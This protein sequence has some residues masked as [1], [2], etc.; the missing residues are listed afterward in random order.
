MKSTENR[1]V[2][3]STCCHLALEGAGGTQ[4]RVRGKVH[5][6]NL[7][8]TPSSVLRTSS[9]SR[10]KQTPNA[11]TLIELLV[12]VL[13]IGI[14]AAVALPQYKKAVIKSRTTEALTMLKTIAD[15]Q[16]VYY[17]S[18]GE[19]TNN[20]SDLDID[21]DEQLVGTWSTGKFE[22]KYTYACIEKRTCGAYVNNKDMPSFE[23]ELLH[24][25]AYLLNAGKKFCKVSGKS[26]IAKSICQSMGTQNAA[27]YNYLYSIN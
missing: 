10:G 26:N 16:E 7:I 12:V 19:Y 3:K 24:D 20:F 15:A 9:P 8:C 11:F 6:D 2:K 22:N 14:L 25:T 21:I 5:K 27:P 13:I 1:I 4:C 17:L 18:N 23:F